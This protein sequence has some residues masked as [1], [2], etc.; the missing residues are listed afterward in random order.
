MGGMATGIVGGVAFGGVKAFARGERPRLDQL[1]LSP[2]N[3]ARIAENL[4]QMR[5]AAMKLGQLLSM[6]TG[7][8]MP[9][10][11]EAILARL[12]DDAHFMPPKQLKAV[13]T[14]AY[15]DDFRAK[16]TGFETTPLAAASIGQVHRA[17]ASN[18]EPV[19]I[20]LQY[21]GVRAAIDSDL[22]NAATLIKWS[23]ML[24]DDLDFSPF[25]QEARRQLHDEADYLRE[26]WFL[27]R[28]GE[29]LEDDPRFVVPRHFPELSGPDALAM[30]FEASEPIEAL[31]KEAPAIR[32]AAVT[33]LIDLCMRELFEFRLM[34]TDPNFANYRWRPSTKQIV[35][36]DF[37]AAR[38]IP[39]DV[40]EGHHRLMCA[41]LDRDRDAIFGALEQLG[42]LRSGLALR[43]REV[44]L[45]MAEMGF[46]ALNAPFDFATNDL[47]ARLRRRGIDIGGER[48]LRHIPP[49]D[50]LFVQRKIGGLYLLASR[51]GARVN[52]PELLARYR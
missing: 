35:L 44:I 40:A 14:R 48:E 49:A 8:M 37:G 6:E 41:G 10:E 42:F 31:A 18:G 1:V 23:G 7:D 22:D 33:A 11:L 46:E 52:F 12:R 38:D 20:K 5:G 19:A 29:V 50:T 17:T 32:D 43:H 47:A 27:Q 51:F 9:P 39:P 26:G 30:S 28:F 25:L 3:I 21:P 36:L 2:G 45:D 34:Q 4:A 15:G 24:P 13:L 16:F